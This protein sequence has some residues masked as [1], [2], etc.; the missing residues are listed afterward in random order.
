MAPNTGD[1]PDS[2]RLEA[3]DK[4]IEAVKTARQKPSKDTVAFSQAE[5][6]WRMVYEMV[7]GLGIGFGIGY[8]LDALFGTQPWLMMVFT[9]FGLAAGVRVMMR[10]AQEMNKA[11]SAAEAAGEK[12]N[13]RG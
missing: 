11:S 5:M 3:L 2:K 7:A 4:R 13:S 12:D 1:E 8:G 6:G 9:L 10:T